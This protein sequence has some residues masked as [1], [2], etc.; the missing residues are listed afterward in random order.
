MESSTRSRPVP[1]PQ[2]FGPFLKV[3]QKNGWCLIRAAAII[4]VHP[5]RGDEGCQEL[6]DGTLI[7]LPTGAKIYVRHLQ[8]QIEEVLQRVY[9]GDVFEDARPAVR[10]DNGSF[11][12][13]PFG[14]PSLVG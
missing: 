14:K 4:G 1:P 3:L 8:P 2:R 12:R 7:R 11:V 9:E 13:E 10:L 6:D 5:C